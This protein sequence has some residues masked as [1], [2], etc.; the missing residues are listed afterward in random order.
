MNVPHLRSPHD[1]VGGIVYFGRMLDKARL[2]ARA[3]LPED[4]QPNLGKAFDERCVKFLRVE[5]RPLIDFVLGGHT[6]EEALE[7]AFEHGRR[8]SEEEI[9]VWNGF[10]T[11]RAWNDEVT[12]ILQR[13]LREGGWEKRR[14]IQT[15]FDY[16]DLDEGRDPALR[17]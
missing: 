6:D 11:K 3:E 9:E 1:Q 4:F 8:P 15:M 10:M 5:Y 14:D 16:I 7:W 12:P 13:R 2:Q 17:T